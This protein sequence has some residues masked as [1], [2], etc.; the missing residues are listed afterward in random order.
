[1]KKLFF[2]L[3][4][5]PALSFGQTPLIYTD[6]V[7]VDSVSQDELYNRA[8]VWFTTTF[9]SANDVIQLDNKQEGQIVGK[10]NMNYT[11]SVFE[12][13]VRIKGIIKYSISIWLKEGRYKYEITDFIHVPTGVSS[14]GN[15]D[16]GLISTDEEFPRINKGMFK[17]WS[18][19]VWKDIKKQIDSN[20]NPLIENLKEGM[21]KKTETKNS[22]W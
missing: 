4:F 12:A 21:L 19:N 14:Y 17:K 2:L 11:P 10:P 22:D 9:I 6:V 8:K 13:N 5:M 20:I 3:L 16:F 15:I 1:M 18:N 7:K